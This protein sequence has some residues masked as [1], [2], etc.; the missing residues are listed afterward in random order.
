MCTLSRRRGLWPNIER[1]ACKWAWEHLEAMLQG[2]DF[3]RPK[4]LETHGI[5]L[6]NISLGDEPPV[7]T[8]GH[9]GGGRV[10]WYVHGAVGVLHA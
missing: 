10:G 7:V 8:G 5:T 4:W 3:W 2:T 6:L 9:A 1:A